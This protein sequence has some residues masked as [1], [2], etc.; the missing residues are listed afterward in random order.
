MST[1]LKNLCIF[2]VTY[3]FL[4]AVSRL[5]KRYSP[6]R[7]PHEVADLPRSE[8]H[9]MM[10]AAISDRAQEVLDAEV[11]RLGNESWESLVAWEG[12]QHWIER[13]RD[14]EIYAVEVTSMWDDRRERRVLRYI[15]EVFY[16]FGPDDNPESWTRELGG[17]VV[18]R[19]VD[20]KVEGAP[21]KTW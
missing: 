11:R 17:R 8:G 4:G 18:L 12:E 3:V 19:H 15:I 7:K 1:A 14:S 9:G 21:L 10:D 20:G 13:P 16:R 6:A 5:R 2:A